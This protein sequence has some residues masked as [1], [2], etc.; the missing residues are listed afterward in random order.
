MLKFSLSPADLRVGSHRVHYAWVIVGVASVM[1]MV[2]SS[3]RFSATVLIPHLQDP[4]G[5]GWS[6]GTIAF[7]FSLQWFLSGLLGPAMGWLGDRHGVRRIMLFGALLFIAGMLLTGT[8]THLWQFYLYFGILL[9]GA[10]SVFQV[11]LVSGVTVWFRKHLG[12]AMGTL[13]ALQASGTV[14]LIPLIAFLFAQFGLKWTFWFPGIIGG[15]LLLLLIRAFYNEPAEIG[16]RPV[17]AP[18]DEPIARLRQDDTAKMR[19]SVFL[20]Q[21]QGTHAFWN[22]IG[23]HFWGCMGHNIFVVF[24]VAMAIDRGLSWDAAIGSYI[25]LNVLSMVSRFLA[26]VIADR[27]GAKAVMAVCFTLQVLPPLILL[28]SQDP[29]AFYLFAGLF[30]IGLG[31]EVPAFPI[32]NRQYFGY[33]PIGTVYGWQMLGNGLGMGLGP[34]VGG[35]LWDITG[36]FA[37]PVILS[38]ALSLVGLVSVLLLPTTSRPLIPNWEESLPPE[39]RSTAS[40]Q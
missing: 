3:I 17:G 10:M 35:I 4:A 25:T 8:M 19:A 39:A 5:F 11:P 9:G 33:A 7:A 28:L 20:R 21:A 18:S 32:I 16:L 22:L 12:L 24:L 31:G 34:L 13:Q 37:S 2:S 23:I 40:P 38:S 14:L 29:W 1:W 6:Y 36:Q 15:V 26:P 27:S 30:G